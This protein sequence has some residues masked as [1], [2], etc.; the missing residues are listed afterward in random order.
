[1]VLSGNHHAGPRT[2]AL[3]PPSRP[4]A[5]A[6]P[7]ETST[8]HRGVTRKRLAMP[9]PGTWRDSQEI[10][11]FPSGAPT[12]QPRSRLTPGRDWLQS[13][14]RRGQ[15]QRKQIE[16]LKCRRTRRPRKPRR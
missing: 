12:A 5:E 7:D 14:S 13:Q 3:D 16:V 15:P 11:V 1:M 9:H 10:R 6:F 4:G 8:G 2:C